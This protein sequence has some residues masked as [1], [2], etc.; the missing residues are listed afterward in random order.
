MANEE[1]M[2]RLNGVP[3]HMMGD[4]ER[5]RK[6]FVDKLGTDLTVPNDKNPFW[7]TGRPTK[8]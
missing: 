5:L 6:F 7:H 3:A 4:V 8:V 2:G 1:P